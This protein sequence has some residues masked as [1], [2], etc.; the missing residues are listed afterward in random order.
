MRA[1]SIGVHT[2]GDAYYHY[3]TAKGEVSNIAYTAYF[4]PFVHTLFRALVATTIVVMHN[5]VSSSWALLGE[6]RTR[7]RYLVSAH[8]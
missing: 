2:L 1:H 8:C 7:R 5:G 3:A 6:M 4:T